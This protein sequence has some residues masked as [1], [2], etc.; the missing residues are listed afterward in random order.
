MFAPILLTLWL[1]FGLVLGLLL[2]FLGLP[3]VKNLQVP[4]PARIAVPIINFAAGALIL[5]L[6]T[7]RIGIWG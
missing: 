7:G 2:F 6:L 5:T 1:P 4:K 3:L